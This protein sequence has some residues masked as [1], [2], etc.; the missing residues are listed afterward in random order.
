MTNVKEE[1]KK[2]Y[3]S[4][5]S[6]ALWSFRGMLRDAP[7]AFWLSALGVPIGVFLA[8]AEIR[9]PALVVAQVVNG[10]TFVQAAW[11]VGVLLGL[12]GLA[13]ASQR[14]LEGVS[15]T[16]LRRYCYQKCVELNRKSMS[17]FYQVYEKKPVRDLA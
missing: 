16:Y 3:R 17:C 7:L 2:P 9:L 13:A 1:K 4:A 11:A 6:N 12:T 8:W 5:G 15:Q 14:A 10:R